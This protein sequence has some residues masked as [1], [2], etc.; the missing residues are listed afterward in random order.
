[1]RLTPASSWDGF[2]INAEEFFIIRDREV[3]AQVSIA[4]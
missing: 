3:V 4:G 2:I 1:V